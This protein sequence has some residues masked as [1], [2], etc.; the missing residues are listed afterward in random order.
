M[1]KEI[2]V[3]GERFIEYNPFSLLLAEDIKTWILYKA[4]ND[5]RLEVLDFTMRTLMNVLRKHD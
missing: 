1:V 2:T 4:T 3:N 5:E